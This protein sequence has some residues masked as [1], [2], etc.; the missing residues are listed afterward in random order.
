MDY[1]GFNGSATSFN[2][3]ADLRFKDADG[4]HYVGFQSPSAV[5]A[6]L[7]WTL[8]ASDGS[9]NRVLK[10]DGSGN[11]NFAEITNDYVAS[12]AAIAGTKISPDF[13]SQNIVTTGTLGSGAITTTG[14]ITINEPNPV[15]F[16]ND[17]G[18]N[19]D[20]EVGNHD[21]V[22]AIQDNTNSANRLVINTDG[23]IDIA[24][25]VDFGAGIDVT[26]NITATGD[27]TVTNADPRIRLVDSDN[28]SD[29]S[30][31]GNGGAF[32]IADETNAANRFSIA[33]N[34][35]IS[36]L[37]NHDFSAGIDVTGNITVTGTVDGVDIATRDTLF[38]GLTASSGVLT[39][40]VNATTQTSSDN[41]TKV[42]TTAYVTTAVN[43]LINGAPAALD[44]LNELAA[45]MND[46][47]AFSTTVTNSLATKM[48]L[49]GGQFTGNI[50][51]SGSQTVDGRDLSV[52]GSKLDGIES[53]ATADQTASD[54]KTLLNSSGLVNAQIDASAA[55]AGS[56]ISPTFT[57]DIT[58]NEANPVIFFNDTGDNPDYEVGNHDGAL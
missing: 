27:I 4:S 51:F 14:D 29:F 10:T 48:P 52:D 36:S 30:V 31:Y 28:D 39:D 13:G 53:G 11:L 38:G 46:D 44:T 2:L 17:S 34:G 45:A 1:I 37:G 55:I 58:I 20:Y 21:G 23:H 16:F 57:S 8:P 18:N 15:I 42:A 49:A 5:G 33:S 47:A 54:I 9:A 56:K 43:N 12:N 7:V 3:L 26:G 19:P 35:T 22:F 40:G 25:N 41:T 24:G 32:T 50:T 6:N